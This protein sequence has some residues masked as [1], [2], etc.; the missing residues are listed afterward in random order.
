MGD[1]LDDVPH[2]V[3]H[4]AEHVVGMLVSLPCFADEVRHGWVC[5]GPEFCHGSAGCHGFQA[6]SLS[7]GA[8]ESIRVDG[9]MPDFA[10]ASAVPV[11]GLPVA[12]E[13]CGQ[14]GAE[15]E[16]YHGC[17]AVYVLHEFRGSDRSRVHIVFHVNRNVHN[18]TD[19]FAEFQGFD[20][21]ID[22]VA[23]LSSC[24]VHLSWN[25]NADGQRFVGECTCDAHDV[26]YNVVFAGMR[27][28]TANVDDAVC[29]VEQHT[30]DFC[31]A[32]VDTDASLLTIVVVQS[33]V[34]CIYLPGI[35]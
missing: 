32:D 10:D 1:D 13:P 15:V 34:H 2:A 26:G 16:E 28:H 31:A 3:R 30:F 12:Y 23:H 11:F 18:L 33:C 27:W 24:A 20:A 4:F 22:N 25:A 21:E 17:V 6:S 35:G 19:A 5:G 14:A 9:K 7:A 8:C 29:C